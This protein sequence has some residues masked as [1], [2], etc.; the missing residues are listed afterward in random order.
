MN[1]HNRKQT[2]NLPDDVTFRGKEA[3]KLMNKIKFIVETMK[4][5]E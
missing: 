5:I 4:I 2:E 1:F 3:T